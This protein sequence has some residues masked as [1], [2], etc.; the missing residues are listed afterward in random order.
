MRTRFNVRGV[1]LAKIGF[2]LVELLVVIAIIGIL[3]ALLLPAVQAAREAARRSECSNNFKQL[4]LAM[5]NYHDT[6]KV[7]PYGYAEAGMTTRR[8]DCWMQRVLPFIE[9][10]PMLDQY[11]TQN[12]TWIMDT[13]PEVKDAQL[14]AFLCP[15]DGSLPAVGGSGG[16]RANGDGFLGNYVMCTGNGLIRHTAD[17]NGMFY[18]LSS[19]NFAEII[20]GTSNTL[21]GSE[22]VRRGK[23]V[24]GWGEP[25]GY[26]GGARWGGYGFTTLEPPN[27]VVPDR[28]YQ[29]KDQNWPQAPCTSIG[30]AD[31]VVLFA[32]SYHPG[33]VNCVLA[34]ASVQFISDTIDLVTYRA[35]STRRGGEPVSGF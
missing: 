21:M 33:G 4:G 31:N 1:R 30:G 24:T 9:Q 25:G 11:E 13:I 15:S 14:D 28:I 2:T 34:D 5:H 27:S 19:T 3:V 29:C 20:D 12:P 7:F 22:A 26:W 10:Q 35:I 23:A 8:R 32:R 6:F 17:L 16:R 18:E